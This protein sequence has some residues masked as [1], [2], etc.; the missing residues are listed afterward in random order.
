MVNL[1]NMTSLS[2]DGIEL[3]SLSIDGIN[4]WNVTLNE[5]PIDLNAIGYVSDSK[6]SEDDGSM[7]SDPGYI[8][9]N[10]IPIDRAT[11]EVVR[12]YINSKNVDY[13]LEVQETHGALVIYQDD[14]VL[15][16]YRIYHNTNVDCNEGMSRCGFE[17]K[18]DRDV[19]SCDYIIFSDFPNI[20]NSLSEARANA[21]AISFYDNTIDDVSISIVRKT[22]T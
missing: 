13:K 17:I 21:F 22:S 3:S 5:E 6:Y 9:I 1:D 11:G 12:V 14:T 2:I 4:V 18:R 20:Y 16:T 8:A 19:C 15:R 10:K 7:I